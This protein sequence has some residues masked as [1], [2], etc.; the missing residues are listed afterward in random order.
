MINRS[1][2]EFL[3][4]ESVDVEVNRGVGGGQEVTEA[5]HVGQPVRPLSQN[6]GY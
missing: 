2:S 3:L 4:L 6:L 1:S 5:G